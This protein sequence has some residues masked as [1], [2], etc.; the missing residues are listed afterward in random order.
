MWYCKIFQSYMI[1]SPSY[2]ETEEFCGGES[3][4]FLDQNSI[5]LGVLTIYAAKHNFNWFGLYLSP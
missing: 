1:G 5:F 2:K 4:W 3:G